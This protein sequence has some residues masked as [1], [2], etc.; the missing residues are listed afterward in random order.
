MNH[1]DHHLLVGQTPTPGS[2]CRLKMP[3][4]KRGGDL[5]AIQAGGSARPPLHLRNTLPKGDL[6]HGHAEDLSRP[7][8]RRDQNKTVIQNTNT[9]SQT[10]TCPLE[11]LVRRL[12]TH[13]TPL[14][15]RALLRV[16]RG[17]PL[18]NHWARIVQLVRLTSPCGCTGAPSRGAVPSGA[19]S[20]CTAAPGWGS[21][22]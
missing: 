5:K 7:L 17:S 19:P 18:G 6:S 8:S 16:L 3:L 15:R 21:S 9:A 4:C 11:M 14:A 22:R 12:R 13:G 10:A 20:G 1:C 2:G